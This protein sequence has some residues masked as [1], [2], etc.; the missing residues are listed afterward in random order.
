MI[1]NFSYCL[2]HRR[3]HSLEACLSIS[4]Q[5]FQ[6]CDISYDRFI[7]CELCF[8]CLVLVENYLLVITMCCGKS[9]ASS[10]CEMSSWRVSHVSV[11]VQTLS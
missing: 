2:L 5:F 4:E 8:V 11:K 9:I 10:Y 7:C 1:T 3:N 6:D